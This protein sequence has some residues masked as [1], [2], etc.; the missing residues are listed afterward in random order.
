MG[1]D[2]YECSDIETLGRIKTRGHT[3]YR[4]IWM[5]RINEII[6]QSYLGHLGHLR[7]FI[8]PRY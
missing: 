7:Q 2:S 3:T 5:Y 1:E 4:C 8:A 6:F